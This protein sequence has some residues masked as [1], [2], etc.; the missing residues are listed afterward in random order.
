MAIDYSETLESNP[1]KK[2]Q[3]YF[4]FCCPKC[5]S[6]NSYKRKTKY[7]IYRCRQCSK[8]FNKPGVKAYFKSFDKLKEFINRYAENQP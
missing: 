8:T 4:Y 2:I 5:W 7:P 1:K 6:M 3:K